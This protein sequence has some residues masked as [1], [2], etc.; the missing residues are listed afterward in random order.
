MEQLILL[1]ARLAVGAGF[2]SAVADRFGWWGPA[3]QK[4]V[5]WGNWEAFVAYTSKLNFGLKGILL[6][7]LAIA[8]TALELVLGILMVVGF[9]LKTTAL[10]GGGLLLLFA[11]AMSLNTGIKAALDFSVFAAAACCFLLYLHPASKWSM[12]AGWR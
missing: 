1:F 6:D 3:G 2:L 9:R 10:L 8:V 5:A 12:D 11:L 4:G 7:T